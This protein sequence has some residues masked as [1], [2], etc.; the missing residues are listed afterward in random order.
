MALRRLAQLALETSLSLLNQRAPR[1][2]R[3]FTPQAIEWWSRPRR[4]AP[5]RK[6]RTKRRMIATVTL[7]SMIRSNKK[8]TEE[9]V[10]PSEKNSSALTTTDLC[11][12]HGPLDILFPCSAPSITGRLFMAAKQTT[13]STT[14]NNDNKPIRLNRDRLP[15][16]KVPSG[17]LS[18]SSNEN[19]VIKRKGHSAAY[20]Y[21]AVFLLLDI[22]GYVHGHESDLSCFPSFHDL[23]ISPPAVFSSEQVP[24]CSTAIHKHF[25]RSLALG[26][27][28][29][30]C[31]RC[32][33]PEIE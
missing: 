30:S 4:R 6:D 27:A 7:I 9:T 33:P 16:T 3:S 21:L 26:V 29:L 31:C 24:S 11:L 19:T 10:R 17:N 28:F 5:P 23:L 13:P 12:V 22:C 20:L 14:S 18:S 15:A 2:E 25:S 8:I 32:F 1:I